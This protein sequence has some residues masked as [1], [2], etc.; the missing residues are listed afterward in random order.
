VRLPFPAIS[1]PTICEQGWKDSTL[2]GLAEGANTLAYFITAKNTVIK[3]F[4]VQA[5]FL[6]YKNIIEVKAGVEYL[7]WQ[8]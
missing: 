8:Q 4:I 7:T 2:K 5:L 3:C 1:I 6:I